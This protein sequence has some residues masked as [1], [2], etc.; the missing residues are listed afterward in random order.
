MNKGN[1]EGDGGTRVAVF[2]GI[3]VSVEK[4]EFVGISIATG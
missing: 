3:L 4:T 1:G 2:V